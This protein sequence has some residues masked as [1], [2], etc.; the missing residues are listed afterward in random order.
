MGSRD[1]TEFPLSA[2]KWHR[3]VSFAMWFLRPQYLSVLVVLLLFFLFL[4]LPFF[5]IVSCQV[6]FCDDFNV[7]YS[8]V[9]HAWQTLKA[10]YCH[11]THDQRP[12]TNSTFQRSFFF[13]LLLRIGFTTS[14]VEVQVKF[15]CS[16]PTGHKWFTN[17]QLK[18]IEMT[19]MSPNVNIVFIAGILRWHITSWLFL[20]KYQS[21]CDRAPSFSWTL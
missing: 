21:Q 8:A 14:I 16:T 3:H 19:F 5:R 18:S 17:L 6:E 20:E 12:G 15:A 11:S 2:N 10:P 9:S 7:D 13:L 1:A 4:S